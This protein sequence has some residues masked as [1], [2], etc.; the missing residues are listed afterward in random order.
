MLHVT[1]LLFL[2]NAIHAFYKRLYGY[3]LAFLA[4]ATTTFFFHQEQ[5]VTDTIWYLDQSAIL[6]VVCC[7][8]VYVVYGALWYQIAAVA[9][10][11]T[12]M[13]LDKT[14]RED[15]NPEEH[16]WIHMLSSVGHH[17]I[18]LGL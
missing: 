8:A 6:V 10:I 3:G 1:G 17:A 15:W 5:Y 18:L 2:T 13:Y 7:G 14:G 4:L 11:A 16:K 12:V 9:C